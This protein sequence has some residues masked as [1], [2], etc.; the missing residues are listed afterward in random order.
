MSGTFI[1]YMAVTSLKVKDAQSLLRACGRVAVVY[2]VVAP[3][4]WPWYAAMPIALL[5][6]TPDATF[7]W[8]IVAVSLA[9]R[10]AA[11]LDALRLNGVMDWEHELFAT[12]IVGV[13]LP[14]A[15][16]VVA[17]A[18]QAWREQKSRRDL[19]AP[20]AI[21]LSSQTAPGR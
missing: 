7:I 21:G 19:R 1:G 5:A 14:A 3:G 11:P 2:L 18:W 15:S 17:G 13:W 16:I 6:L 20:T 4:Y 10:L 9:S 8:S 12:T